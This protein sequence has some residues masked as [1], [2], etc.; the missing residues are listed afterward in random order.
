MQ[1]E[2]SSVSSQS[3]L[4]TSRFNGTCCGDGKTDAVQ[5]APQEVNIKVRIS[6]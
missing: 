4:H 3:T 5:I 6:K 1:S 2:Y